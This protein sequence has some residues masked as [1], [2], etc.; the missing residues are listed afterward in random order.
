MKKVCGIKALCASN[1]GNHCHILVSG[2]NMLFKLF[3]RLRMRAATEPVKSCD[4]FI[5]MDRGMQSIGWIPPKHH[6]GRWIYFLWTVFTTVLGIILLDVSLLVSYFKELST[7]SAGQFLTSLQVS[8]NCFGSS[9]KASYTFAGIKRFGLAK[10]LL[11]RLDERCNRVEEY[12]QLQRAVTRCNRFYMAYQ[13]MYLMYTFSTFLSNAFSG[14]LPWKLYNPLFD[15]QTS[16]RNFWLAG[17]MEYFWM[18][19]AVMQDLMADVYPVIYFLI[20]RAHIGLLKQRLQRLRTDP[21][22]SEEQNYEELI[23]CIDDH[24]VILEYCNTL[25]PIVSATIFI[26]F[27]L[28]GLVMGLSMINLLFFSNFVTG[29]GTAIFLFDLVLQTFP[30]C[31]ICNMIMDDCEELANCLFHSNWLSADRRYKTTL[32]YFLHNVQK[33]IV[34]SAGGVFEISMSSNITVAKLAFSVVTF[35]KQLNIAEKF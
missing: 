9:I 19:I 10:K 23:K 15:W 27:L 13:T 14:R 26:Q 25:R 20:L 8:F 34:L 35:V 33:P 17:L 21:T 1:Y 11:D 24:R 7:F 16:T 6:Y 31:F 5:Y 28:C 30:F 18:T 22:M 29:L 12:E 3:P 32:R 4:A 2:G